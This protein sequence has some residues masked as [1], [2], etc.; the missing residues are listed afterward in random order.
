MLSSSQWE[1][2]IKAF[3]Q[4]LSE[5][6]KLPGA[7][8]GLA[9]SLLAIGQSDEALEILDAFPQSYEYTLAQKLKPVAKAINRLNTEN[10]EQP[11]GIEATYQHSLRLIT[12]GNLPAALDGLLAVLRQN[13][14]YRDEEARQVILGIFEILGNENPIT[15]QYRNEL[16][17]ILF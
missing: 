12:L 16:A 4:V 2:A 10:S 14:R 11:T 5:R 3:Q 13:K 8:I 9:K 1:D 17:T 15:R 7:L 6:P